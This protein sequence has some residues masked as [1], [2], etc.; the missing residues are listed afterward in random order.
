MWTWEDIEREW[1][2]GSRIAYTAQEAVEAF[3]LVERTLGRS[4]M[5]EYNSS[6]GG[7][8]R[9]TG[10][11]SAIVHMGLRLASLEGIAG[12]DDLIARIKR[13]DVSAMAELTAIHLLR[14]DLPSEQRK[15]L[16]WRPSY[17]ESPMKMRLRRWSA[18]FASS[19]RWRAW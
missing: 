10:P 1:L 4:W 7:Q 5:K 14:R 16:G 6:G 3:N 2:G 17:A 15:R 13:T 8:V 12:P 19:A 11:T 9:G 18:G